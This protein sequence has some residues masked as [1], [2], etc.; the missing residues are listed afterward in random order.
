MI[1]LPHPNTLQDTGAFPAMEGMQGTGTRLE[2]HTGT[3]R[4]YKA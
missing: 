1:S 3:H 4:G 2:G